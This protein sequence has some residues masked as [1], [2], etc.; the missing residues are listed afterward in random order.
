MLQIKAAAS[1]PSDV[2]GAKGYAAVATAFYSNVRHD[3]RSSRPSILLWWVYA[4]SVSG[5]T[6]EDTL[7][8]LGAVDFSTPT[9][10]NIYART[11]EIKKAI[12]GYIATYNESAIEEDV[13]TYTDY[14]AL[15]MSGVATMIDAVSSI[16]IGIITYISVLEA[17]EGN[18]YPT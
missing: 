3:R 12:D 1:D 15:L 4:I 7:L 10:I 17:Y 2:F 14:M 5:S 13:I 16:M 8:T 18:W 9:T 6:L 11:F